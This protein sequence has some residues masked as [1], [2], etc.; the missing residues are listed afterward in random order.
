MNL[1]ETGPYEM[2][3]GTENI[4]ELGHIISYKGKTKMSNWGDKYCGQLN[5]SDS[6]I[7]PPID[8]DNVPQKMYV[9]EPEICR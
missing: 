4:R 6:T 2:I 8:E 1:T 9:F 7:Y 3:R 5:G